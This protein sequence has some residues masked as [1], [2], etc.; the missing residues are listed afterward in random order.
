MSG[1]PL[2]AAVCIAHVL[3]LA[4]FAT[5][6]ALLP[7]F[8]A[9]WRITNTE[10]GWISGIFFAGYAAAVPLLAGLTDRI[11]ARRVYIFSAGLGV[12]ASVGFALF[13]DGFWTALGF[14]A[15]LG[16][17]VAGTYM[18]GLK[19]LT[20]RFEGPTQSRTLAFY[21]SS[22]GVGAS[23]SFLLSG[24]IAAW[25]DWRWAFGLAALGSAA[26]V[27]IVASVLK[28]RMPAARPADAIGHVLDFRP[29]LRNRPAMGYVLAYA[30]HSWEL[31]AL[32]AWIVAFLVF[33]QGIQPVGTALMSAT[34]I[35]A[36][37]NLVGVPASIFGNELAVRFGRRR[38]VIFIMLV[39]TAMGVGIGFTAP[40]PYAVVIALLFLYSAVISGDSASITA[41]AVA[42][43]VRGQ[44][45]A[46]MAVHSFFGFTTSFLGPLAFGIVLDL[47]GGNM[48]LLAWGIAFAVMGLGAG[49]GPIA[50]ALLGCARHR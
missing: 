2:V 46:T 5:F 25:L 3:N 20:D 8:F 13:A 33:S 40:L 45:G 27:G 49:I 37:V 14:R 19:L 22:F 38:V 36:A 31:M 23:I 6:P 30:A 41:G 11:D 42:A 39:S 15:L 9:E 29:V 1:A 44:S 10:A 18:P 24:E 26:A 48:S 7:T 47:L 17:A 35:A 28:P 12:F 16:V 32:R 21:T 43:A 34:V 50:L 4:G